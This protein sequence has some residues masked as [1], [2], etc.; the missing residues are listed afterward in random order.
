MKYAKIGAVLLVV[1]LVASTPAT[2]VVRGSPDLDV[3]APP[4]TFVPG[5]E[6][7]LTLTVSNAGDLDI[8]SGSNSALN[9]EVTTARAV[10]VELDTSG[11][12]VTTT[13]GT[14]TIGSL[15]EGG[16]AQLPF[17][18]V[19]DEDAAPG[20]YTL[21]A[22]VE[23]VYTGNV[24]ELNGARQTR[25]AERS[26]DV[27]VR[28]DDRA[29][30]EVVN[31]ETNVRVGATGTVS[32]TLENVGE[33]TA[34]SSAVALQ[35]QNSDL[36][37]GQS[38]SGTRVVGQ[39][40]SGERRTI[41]YQ[42][43]AA[44]SAEQHAYAFTAQVL[45]DDG[46]G[47]P[48]RSE[49]LTVG[50][51]PEAEQRF[52]VVSTESDVSVGESGDLALTLRNDGPIPVGDVAVTVESQSPHVVFG[53]TETATRFVGEWQPGE[54]RTLGYDLTATDAADA[55][56]Y[57]LE[58][59]VSYDDQAG[60]RATARPLS[61]A[62]SPESERG[63][64]LSNVSSTLRVGEEGEITGTI[65][66][67]RRSVARDVVVHLVSN[68][69]T[70]HPTETE[71]AVGTLESGESANFS[72]SARADSRADPVPRQ[73]AFRATYQTPDNRSQ[74][75][76]TLLVQRAVAPERTRLE[77]TGIET[78]VTTDASNRIVLG[79]R[80]T[81]DVRFQNV[82][83]RVVPSA[84]LSSASPEA[85]TESI[86]AGEQKEFTFELA[87]ADD[88]VPTT[89]GLRV[90]VVAEEPDGDLYRSDRQVAVRVREPGLLGQAWVIVLLGA[91]VVGVVLLAG[92]RLANRQ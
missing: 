70:V 14:R 8:G 7:T 6:S 26:F 57:A 56:A 61:L 20:T 75:S 29:R 84:P 4:Q 60:S 38:R 13:P 18:I 19:V 65:T 80:N 88:A 22:D 62:V 45:F 28:V 73:F 23:Y 46:E 36:G 5:E 44:S 37:F 69:T 91:V 11:T 89:H 79:V 39:W 87:V 74:R 76:D 40:D 90:A 43:T 9:T 49:N 78:N 16:A 30:F 66:N 72:V 77:V 50:V 33:E 86:D 47:I 83:V 17:Q 15:P 3:T 31:T 81:A 53:G 58:A 92:Q 10:D 27:E 41:Q 71:Y 55:R 2:A 35:S 67:D 42:V 82:T 12:P 51:T 64:S 85:Y 59:T 52:S 1:L 63:F 32:V 24:G 34:T 68:H 25:T 48:R 54:T 21:E